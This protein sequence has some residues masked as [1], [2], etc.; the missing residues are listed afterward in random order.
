MPATDQ[1]MRRETAGTKFKTFRNGF[2]F[3][4]C[5][6]LMLLEPLAAAGLTIVVPLSII[7]LEDFMEL[8][9]GCL[10][11]FSI[12]SAVVLFIY[13]FFWFSSIFDLKHLHLPIILTVTF[14]IIAKNKEIIIG[15]CFFLLFLFS[16]PLAILA[17]SIAFNI[18]TKY[19]PNKVIEILSHT[20]MFIIAGSYLITLSLS[21]FL[22]LKS[23]SLSLYS[24]I[25]IAH[26][27]LLLIIFILWL[28]KM[29]IVQKYLK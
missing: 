26:S 27:L 1:S 25:P 3:D 23:K 29:D 8:D 21:L 15:V 13:S 19:T 2:V 12:L 11:L 5:N 28:W 16:F 18:L 24:F 9:T 10:L 4:P 7:D 20:I 6:L 22:T 14:T 17:V